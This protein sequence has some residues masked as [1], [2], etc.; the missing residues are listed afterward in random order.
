M[1]KNLTK[2]DWAILGVVTLLFL[3]TF[4]DN[5]LT[6]FAATDS[7]VFYYIGSAMRRG[8]VPYRDVFDHK[9][10]LIYFLN[11]L[12][13][14]WGTRLTGVWLI[15]IIVSLAALILAGKFLT[16]YYSKDVALCGIAV[17]TAI[18]AFFNMGGNFTE[19]YAHLFIVYVLLVVVSAAMQDRPFNTAE[20]FWSGCCFAAILLLRP[21]MGV[22][23]LVAAAYF[24]E[25]FART[26]DFKRLCVNTLWVIAGLTIFAFPFIVYL[27]INKALAV[28][29]E[30]Y[31]T[32]NLSYAVG[33]KSIGR[34]PPM[35]MALIV[36]NI[37]VCTDRKWRRAG[38]YN[39]LFV[40][41]NTGLLY[42]NS[43]FLHY[44]IM[45]IPG[46][47]LPCAWAIG[48]M[49]GGR[50][51]PILNKAI[52]LGAVLLL[53]LVVVQYNMD[54]KGYIRHVAQTKRVFDIA[55]YREGADLKCLEK[56]SGLIEDKASVMMLGNDC[57][58]YRR[59]GV[60]PRGY[61]AYVP[62]DFNGKVKE[63]V[64]TDMRAHTNRYIITNNMH[65]KPYYRVVLEETY[66]NICNAGD[67]KLWEARNYNGNQN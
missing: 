66:D 30:C 44:F 20:S 58:V 43:A 6:D 23:G 29:W 47:I 11:Y 48:L 50:F 10:P 33:T 25:S 8:I 15:E 56:F 46:A 64:W 24:L 26:K 57:D 55:G 21:N 4:A 67:Y 36:L 9:G 5:P 17:Y 38:L 65:V 2:V 41:G 59:L 18:F 3:F 34:I 51:A 14:F 54:I 13:S 60:S 53:A 19:T 31:I 1:L 40:L 16:R 35:V 52:V 61:Y 7:G 28:G 27:A 45:L 22:V 62:D 49:L 12:G 37:F 63:T 32:Y 39:L 42:L